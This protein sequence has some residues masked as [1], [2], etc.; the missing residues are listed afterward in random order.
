MPLENGIFPEEIKIVKLFQ[1][2]NPQNITNY[3]PIYVLQCFPKVFERIM[4]NRFYKYLW[5]RKLLYSKQ[6]GF[7][8]GHSTDHVFFHLVDQVC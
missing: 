5:E 2:F 1:N 7:Q 6:F 4:Y 3:C 8:E